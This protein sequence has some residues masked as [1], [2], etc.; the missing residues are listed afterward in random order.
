MSERQEGLSRVSRNGISYLSGD[1][2]LIT[3]S[4]FTESAKPGRPSKGRC[5]SWNMWKWPFA[6][7]VFSVLEV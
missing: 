2:G 3:E 6:A 4:W 5:D 7:S 1:F